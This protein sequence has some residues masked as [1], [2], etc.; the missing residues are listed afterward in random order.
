MKNKNFKKWALL[1]AVFITVAVSA[2]KK[3]KTDSEPVDPPTT[4][5]NAK[6]TSTTNRLELSNDSLFLYAKEIYF[7]NESLPS[8]DDY[9]P[10]KYSKLSATAT[11]SATLVNLENN[12]F[13]LIKVSG[14]A[15]YVSTSGSPKYSY[16][17]DSDTD[18][19]TPTSASPND[20]ASVDLEGNG[21]DVGIYRISAVGQTATEYRLYISA[22][23]ENSPAFK[24]GLSRGAYITHINGTKIGAIEQTATGGAIASSEVNLI[25]STIYGN[26]TSITVAGVKTNGSSFDVTLA[27]TS[28]KS[29]PIFKSNVLTAGSRKIGY[30]AYARFSNTANSIDTL[31]GVFK[32]FAAKGVTDL[33][34]DL[35]YNGGGYVS[36]AEHLTNLIAPSTASG[37]MYIEHFNNNLKNRKTTDPSILKNQPLLDANDK[38]QYNAKGSMITY[39]DI[40]Y[41]V[42]N[43]T[44][45]FAKKGNLGGVTNVVFIVSGGTASASE[46]V[47]NSLKPKMKVTLVGKTT[48]GKP[49]GFF[50]VT[51]EN[52][53]EVYLS[54]F[55]TRNSLDQGGYY[56]GMIPE[57]DG[58]SDLGNYDF[59]NPLDG[60]LAKAISVLAPG[61]TA[62][63]SSNRLSSASGV[64]TNQVKVNANFDE[65][66]R[67]FVGMIETRLKVKK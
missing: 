50:P 41:S 56:T 26:P 55:E 39:A 34:I 35:R 7:W 18:N 67:G 59:G 44:N 30:L 20:Q 63:V 52:R 53:Y 17:N 21:N 48:Y 54:L 5:T 13:N 37:V 57:V 29:S 12:L 49:V 25:N 47:I 28:Y 16:I 32:D 27:K 66:G 4:E 10:R 43:N 24:A 62:V 22:V 1:S 51:L 11:E 36:T 6:Q 31:N 60:Y 9:E 8:Y 14:K 3:N 58:G 33:V 64:K 19:P 42:A 2:C 38:V 23:F 61:A 46:L 65:E 45:N 15:D 40:D